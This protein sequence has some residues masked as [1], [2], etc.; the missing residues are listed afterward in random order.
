MKL[1]LLDGSWDVEVFL[2]RSKPGFDDNVFLRILEV[3]PE[4]NRLL[5]ANEITLGITASDAR[6]LAGLLSGVAAQTEAAIREEAGQ[7]AARAT[8]PHPRAKP[9]DARLPFTKLQGRYLVF[10]HRYQAKF[11]CS[12]AESDLQRH[13]LVSSPTVNSMVQRLERLR[14]IARTPG[15]ARS[16][17]LLVP[18]TLLSANE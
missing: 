7:P 10:I 6:R 13:F 12:P 3:C 9:A 15:Q 16:I 2:D 1:K 8:R 17:R 4:P 14:L 5:R 18:P 11:G